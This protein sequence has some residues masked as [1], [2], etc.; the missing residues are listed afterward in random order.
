MISSGI[1]NI[2]PILQNSR[3]FV[4]SIRF[5]LNKNRLHVSVN[6]NWRIGVELSLWF[7]LIT[8]LLAQTQL[9]NKNYVKTD[10]VSISVNLKGTCYYVL[11]YNSLKVPSYFLSSRFFYSSTVINFTKCWWNL[12][13]WTLTCCFCYDGFHI[14]LHVQYIW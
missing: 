8:Y 11:V 4:L 9:D 6:L 7:Y 10:F 12:L 3:N 5:L 13:K 2:Y 14:M 1:W